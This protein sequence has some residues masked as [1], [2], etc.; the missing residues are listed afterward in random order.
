MNPKYLK[1]ITSICQWLTGATFVFSGIVKAIDPVGTSIK[2]G[3]YLQHFGMGALSDVS[4]A[5]AWILSILEFTLGMYVIMGRHRLVSGTILL[6]FMGMM[7][8]LT[9]YL[10]IFNP[11][12]DCGCFGDAVVLTNWETFWKNIALLLMAVWLRLHRFEQ[13]HFLSRHFHTIYFYIEVVGVIILLYIGTMM[14]PYLD[15]RPFRPGVNIAPTSVDNG[16]AEEYVIIY[17]KGG[18]REEFSL[19]NLPADDSGWEFVETKVLKSS[20]PDALSSTELVLF[21]DSGE[22]VTESVLGYPDYVMLLLSPT[23]AE[24]NEHDIDRI[25]NLYEYALENNYPFYCVT[26]KDETAIERWRYRTGSEYPFLYADQ[27][28]IETM[29]RSNP[30][31]MLLHNGV[32]QWK[33]HLPGIDIEQLTSAKLSEQTLGQI[34]PIDRK[35]HVF[36][37]FVWLIAPMLLYLPMQI[38]RF[39][40]KNKQ[41]K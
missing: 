12:E 31:F 6:I 3:E 37:I 28:V 30:G 20:A 21:D 5:L 2:V 26:L 10:A 14:L 16:S 23:L 17:E 15:F 40:H 9:L 41:T 35:K 29:I 25:E 4:I 11:I 8:P 39:I 1:V 22:D 33:S 24:A 32:I 18:Q 38:I 13:T 7:T 36:W 34:Q 27:Q 19:D